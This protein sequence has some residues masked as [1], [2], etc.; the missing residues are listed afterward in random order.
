MLPDAVSEGFDIGRRGTRRIVCPAEIGRQSNFKFTRGFN[1]AYECFCK[2]DNWYR[3]LGICGTY[4][5]LGVFM[6]PDA[7]K[8]F[9][10]G[11]RGTRRQ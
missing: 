5:I 9:D 11:R 10:I 8:G 1:V 7:V 2:S 4:G 3:V 6:L